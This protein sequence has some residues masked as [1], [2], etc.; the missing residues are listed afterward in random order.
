MRQVVVMP[1]GFH[2]FHAGH[3]SL[4]Q[5]AIKAFPD[6]EVYVAAT[7][8]TKTRPFPFK[9]KEKLAKVAGVAPGHFV[10]VK[11][12]F[13]AEEITSHYNPNEDVLIF[14]RSEKD[15]NEQ[16]KPGGTKK[17]GTSAYFQPWTG[18]DLQPFSQ[19]AYMAYLPTVEFGPG[20][21]SATE[22][23]NA[24]PKLSD[25]RK[26]A[27]VMSLYP[28]TQKN[29]KL[30]ANVVKLLDMGMGNELDEGWKERVGAAALA[31]G[32]AL[33]GLSSM[34][35]ASDTNWDKFPQQMRTQQDNS[36]NEKI[37]SVT[38]PNSKGEYRVR[39]TA[40]NDVHEFITKTP[41]KG[42]KEEF[43]PSTSQAMNIQRQ[44]RQK[45]NPG[46]NR[47][48]WKRPNQISGSHTE[49]E[50]KSLN[51]KYSAKY[52][53][54]GGTQQMWDR[55][56]SK[57]NE[58]A[59]PSSDRDDGGD[60]RS[61]RIRKL[62]EI[63]IQVAKEKNVDEL[64]MIHGMNMI[65]GDDFFNTAVEGILPDITDKE[66]MFVLQSAY[67]TVKQGLAE[68]TTV[69]RI[70]S[71]PITDFLSSLKAYKHTDD[72]SQ[73]GV[74]TG[75][76][77]YWKNK[78]LKTNTT[79][80]LFAGDPKRTALY[81]TGNAHET[82]YVEFTQDG[83]P[84]VYFDRKDLPAMRSRK[85][86]LTVFDASDFRQ[87]P[88]GEW[89]SENPSKP[90]K[91]VPIGDPFKYIA[92]QGWIVR[93][94]DDLDKVF[95]QVK[96]MH[97][98]GKIA[99]Y[100]AEGMNESKQ[101]V[102]EGF[103]NEIYKM[104]P[105]KDSSQGMTTWAYND[106]VEKK[107]PVLYRDSNVIIF[108]ANE[109]LLRY[110]ILQDGNPVLYIGLSKF[111]DG[112]KSGTVATEVAGRGKGLAQKAYLNVS[113][114][115]GVPIY[116]DTTQTDASRLGIWDKLIQQYPERIV[117]YDQKTNK[118]LPLSM[119]DKG[120]VVNQ[121]QPIYVDRNKK[122]T[123]KP[124]APN[125]RY[126]TRVLKLLPIKQGVAEEE[127]THWYNSG[128]KDAQRDAKQY[129]V[130][131]SHGGY[132][133]SPLEWLASQVTPARPDYII[134]KIVVIGDSIA[135][136]IG[137]AIKGAV[138]NATVGINS[139]KILSNVSRDN[140]VQGAK[141]AIVSAGSNDIVKG[142]G[143]PQKLTANIAAI[144][145]ALNAEKYVW[146]L[147]YDKVASQAVSNAVGGDKTVDL[148]SYPSS[149][150]LHPSSYSDV[151]KAAR[152]GLNLSS[153]APGAL[154]T[155][156]GLQ[157][158]AEDQKINLDTDYFMNEGCGIFAVATALNEPGSQIYIISNKEGESWSKSFPYEITHVFAN[159]P[160]KGQ[161]DVRGKRSL[162]EMASDF[163]LDK[164]D[165]SVKGPFDPKEFFTKFMGNSDSKPLYG[166][167]KDIKQ[168]QKQIQPALKQ[169]MAEGLK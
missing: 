62:L 71:K 117:G 31:G 100:G 98:A 44:T 150:G 85:T 28:A 70:D 86:Y 68:G 135:V 55:L 169:G 41:P 39:I 97:K 7:N 168:V 43:R 13:K 165:Y 56:T 24:W 50:L 116:S 133:M 79:K 90:I 158:V 89:F 155:K 3:A 102:A 63:A 72:W 84:I 134:R 46:T 11:S 29:P 128:I 146:I 152:A 101:G 114:I 132:A 15:K 123:T 67:K 33:G 51:F 77:S 99:Q 141:L 161:H 107:S 9:I 131:E 25:K 49:N 35:N 118:N 137:Q 14:V 12:P 27:M 80:G 145:D 130:Q 111:L 136:G 69:T 30:A 21:T 2:P 93:V 23:R 148:K 58:F 119:T 81:A 16:P 142:K 37:M 122:D 60:S 20:I 104:P 115:L 127:T 147:P 6:A 65:A 17:D 94:T 106:A 166:T 54:W 162:E 124:I 95:K 1:G 153:T 34:G 66:Y 45:M 144:K 139:S 125:Q 151:A 159:I 75:D 26:I 163:G 38:G 53:M 4:Y 5:S 48:V 120:P 59:P 76:D 157:G 110:I 156:D 129:P 18:K 140:K 57:V 64:G 143:N 92:S 8:D 112:Y 105:T 22:I 32:V 73:S 52:N 40:G 154:R 109:D 96:N 83:Q 113:D 82:R 138:V 149:D 160:G 91:Q 121:N 88:T 108:K 19:H 78:N 164:G 10:Q 126:R 61:R 42:L 47:F 36:G 74:D 103:L 167:V 87:L